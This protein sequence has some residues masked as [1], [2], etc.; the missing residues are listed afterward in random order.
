M[1]RGPPAQSRYTMAAAAGATPC[2]E[3]L[4]LCQ[5]HVPYVPPILQ[6]PCGSRREAFLEKH[7]DA[8]ASAVPIRLISCAQPTQ[9]P[10]RTA[11]GSIG[12]TL[13]LGGGTFP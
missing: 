10:E 4:P 1:W 7:S 8:S 11:M 13:Q 2:R 12:A 3:L 6:Q 9:H 5:K